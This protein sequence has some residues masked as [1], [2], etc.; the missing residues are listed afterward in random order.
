MNKAAMNKHK[1]VCEYG[2]SF[3][4]G[5]YRGVRLLV[6]GRGMSNFINNRQTSQTGLSLGSPLHSSRKS[7]S[8]S[9]SSPTSALLVSFTK[10]IG[11]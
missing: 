1:S 7:C 4:Q 9:T 5:H 3:L 10:P 11:C 8:C 2:L 6:I